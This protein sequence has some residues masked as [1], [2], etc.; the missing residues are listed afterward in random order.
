MARVCSPK[1]AIEWAGSQEATKHVKKAKNVENIKARKA[2]KTRSDWIKDTQKA[3]NKYIRSRDDGKPCISCNETNPFVRDKWGGVWDCGH[4]KGVG[5]YPELRFEELN[6]HRQCKS[7]NGASHGKAEKIREQYDA[8][9]VWR[10]GAEGVSSILAQANTPKK[11]TIDE[12]KD[13]CAKF[14]QMTKELEAKGV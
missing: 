8:N 14:K 6:A 4:W 7:C 1:C 3:F 9:I 12:L 13:L 11:Y 2:L 5:A 10:I